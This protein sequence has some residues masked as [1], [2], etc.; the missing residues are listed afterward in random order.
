MGCTYS[1][2]LQIDQI[3]YATE[4]VCP[5][6]RARVKHQK[7]TRNGRYRTARERA[8]ILEPRR[9]RTFESGAR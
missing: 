9:Q 1:I 6:S 4:F 7:M 3:R 8:R 2:F 5:T